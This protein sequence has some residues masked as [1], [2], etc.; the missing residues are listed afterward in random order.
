MSSRNPWK[1]R[2]WVWVGQTGPRSVSCF[3]KGVF[4]H[5]EGGAEKTEAHNPSPCDF[6]VWMG[7]GLYFPCFPGSPLGFY[8]SPVLPS[9][10][11]QQ[12]AWPRSTGSMGSTSDRLPF[13]R[14]KW[15]ELWRRVNSG[16]KGQMKEMFSTAS[17]G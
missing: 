7:R 10:P 12:M 14:F 6:S 9:G 13:T 5:A 11:I 16:R 4:L 17:C 15:G 2:H 3:F 1:W 8:S